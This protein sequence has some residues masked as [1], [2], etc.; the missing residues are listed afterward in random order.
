MS[1]CGS[2]KG[3]ALEGDL[4]DFLLQNI[5]TGIIVMNQKLEITYRNGEGNKFLRRYGLPREVPHIGKRI[6]NAFH[7][8]NLSELFPGE[9]YIEKKIG[10]STSKWLFKLHMVESKTPCI[11]IFIIEEAVS[12]QLNMNEIRLRYRLTRR[13]TDVLRRVLKGLKNTDVADELGISGQTVKDHL[14]SIYMKIGIRN[15]NDLMRMF[16]RSDP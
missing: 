14:S 10:S 16:I 2:V 13:E 5:P 6:L 7:A 4:A 3:N 1:N 11:V 8:E 9:V 15:R 12:N